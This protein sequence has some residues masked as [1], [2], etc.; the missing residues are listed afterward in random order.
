MHKTLDADLLKKDLEAKLQRLVEEDLRTWDQKR[1]IV[2]HFFLLIIMTI[3]DIHL[4]TVCFN[5]QQYCIYFI[6]LYFI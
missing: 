4:E 3:I 6:L 5:K 1:R 2:E